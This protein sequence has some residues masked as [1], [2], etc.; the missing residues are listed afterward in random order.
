MIYEYK[1]S[2]IHYQ[3]DDRKAKTTNV[4][5]HGWGCDSSSLMFC[6][7]VVE[8]ENCLFIDFP[9]FGASC[10]KIKDWTVFTYANMVISLCEHLKIEKFNLI[11]HSFGGRIAIILSVICKDKTNKLVLIDSAGLKPRHSLRYYRNILIYKMRKRLKMDISK[12]GSRDYLALSDDMKGVFKNIV[13]TNLDD[14]L[15]LI[16]SETLIIFGKDDKVT[17]IY[18]A[19][20]FTRRIKNSKMVLLKEA[21]HFSYIDRR[22]EFANQLESFLKN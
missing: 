21:G 16:N 7:D 3:F 9:P 13:N 22:L 14:F 19:K 10:K 8:N 12:Y 20:R 1:N 15:P 11:G 17:P 5:L 6:K 2:E 18:M 4:F